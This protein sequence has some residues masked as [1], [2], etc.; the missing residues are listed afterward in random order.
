M[1]GWLETLPSQRVR[2]V[3]RDEAGER[4]SKTFPTRKQAKAFLESA[5]VASGRGQWIGPRGGQTLFCDWAGRWLAARFT[6]VTTGPVTRAACA[7]TCCR[8]R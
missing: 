3:Y 5:L 1:S 8:S 2:A 4:H 7:C 6:R